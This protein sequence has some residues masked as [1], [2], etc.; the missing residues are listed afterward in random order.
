MTVRELMLMVDSSRLLT[1]RDLLYQPRI[2]LLL[3]PV[4]LFVELVDFL[5]VVHGAEFGFFVVIIGQGLIVHGA[6]GL[7]IQRERELFLP[8]KRVA[9]VAEGIVAVLRA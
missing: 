1:R 4:D 8:V 3:D 7:R 2:I 6:R 9:R 5:R